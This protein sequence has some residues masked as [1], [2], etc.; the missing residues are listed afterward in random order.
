MTK[1]RD[2]QE[3]SLT[4]VICSEHPLAVQLIQ[5]AVTS[6]PG[7]LCTIKTQSGAAIAGRPSNRE[8]LIIDT[9][10]VRRWPELL[11]QLQSLEC[12]TIAI[13]SPES[14]GTDEQL[15]GVSL[16]ARG[17]V[18]MSAGLKEEL[19]KAIR[20]VVAGKLWI[21]R[22]TLDDYIQRTNAAIRKVHSC[23]I[24]PREEQI[25]RFLVKGA[26]NKQIGKVLSLSERTVKFHVSN[27][28]GKL[29]IQSRREL[30]SLDEIC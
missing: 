5:Q 20:A 27:I 30:L 24:T 17:I 11:L 19:P 16:G 13:V 18:A 3:D 10:S 23:Q 29:Q 9:Y 21:K 14:G 28:M 12:R 8:I 6:D 15:Q 26:S 1:R 2:A 22:S 25:L 7:L 4:V